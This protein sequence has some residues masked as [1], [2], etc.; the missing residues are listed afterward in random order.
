MRKIFIEKKELL[1]ILITSLE[2]MFAQN[3][4][5]SYEWLGNL[6]RKQSIIFIGGKEGSKEKKRIS[7]I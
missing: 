4:H 5:Y 7:E 6:F 1:K 3:K 2:S